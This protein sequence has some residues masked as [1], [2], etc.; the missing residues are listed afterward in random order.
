MYKVLNDFIEKYHENT[1]YKKGEEY[2]KEGFKADPKRVAFLQT[3]KSKYKKAFLGPEIKKE[4]KPK[5]PKK[6]PPNKS[7][8]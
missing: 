3:D 2:P 4:E 7:D 1:L 8:K 6:N 5:K